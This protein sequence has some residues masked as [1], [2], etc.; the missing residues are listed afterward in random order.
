MKYIA[1][2]GK[3]WHPDESDV[4]EYIKVKEVEADSLEEVFYKMQGEVWSPNGEARELIQSLGLHHTS[5]STGDFIQN[6]H[7]EFYR[8]ESMGFEKY[9]SLPVG[10]ISRF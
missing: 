6:E 1:W 8:V 3:F 5:M 7:G 2:Y 9:D 4:Q 10:K